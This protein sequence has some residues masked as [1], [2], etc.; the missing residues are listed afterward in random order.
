ME[1][2]EQKIV[3]VAIK[4][5]Q[6]HGYRKVTMSDIAE[7]AEMSRPSLYASFENKESIFEALMRQHAELNEAESLKQLTKK[8]NLRD[9]LD[10]LFDVWII[11]PVA[12]VIDSE[13]GKELLA[14]VAIYSP[15][16]TNA[17][18]SKFEAMLIDVLKPEITSKKGMSAQDLAHILML[19]TKGLK[20]ST[21]SLDE[22]K[23]LVDGLI[24]M[25]VASTGKN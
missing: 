17:I 13:N 8:K 2:K 10:C 9:R 4:L 6:R 22:L 23:R 24:S 16:G 20:A 25:A 14:N 1:T 15:E 21:E 5:F 12:S 7:G 3:N 18:Y 19:A 11:Q